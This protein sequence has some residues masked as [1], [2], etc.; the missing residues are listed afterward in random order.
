MADTPNLSDPI[1][2]ALALLGQAYQ[3]TGQQQ[4][5]FQAANQGM[6]QML[7]GFAKQ[8]IDPS[9]ITNTAMPT[10]G[11]SG[12]LNPLL[13]AALGGLA[14]GAS[15]KIPFDKIAEAIKNLFN[16]GQTSIQ[17]NKPYPGGA[18]TGPSAYDPS[19][20]MGWDPSV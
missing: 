17:G 13:A 3:R 10:T 6:F 20:F 9:A 4:P 12:G 1:S 18:L 7:P 11:G 8:G 2:A 15:S 19:H 16:H 5:L 14:G